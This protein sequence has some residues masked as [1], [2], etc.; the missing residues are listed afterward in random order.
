MMEIFENKVH[1]ISK[2]RLNISHKKKTNSVISISFD[3]TATTQVTMLQPTLFFNV[4]NGDK[5]VQKCMMKK[6]LI[7]L[8]L[9][10]INW[11]IYAFLVG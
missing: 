5:E 8:V 1:Y 11:R 2:K 10:N 3:G 6:I 7:V 4:N 9:M